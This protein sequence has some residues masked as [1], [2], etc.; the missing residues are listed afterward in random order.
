MKLAHSGVDEFVE[1][2]ATNLS[3]GGMFIRSREP[4][5]LGT[6]VNFKVEIAG[7]TRVL[8]GS[9]VV[10]WVREPND[11]NGPPGMGLEFS[12]LDASSEALVIRMLSG[13][14]STP[15]P[16]IPRPPMVPAVVAPRVAPPSAPRA[17][18]IAP[19]PSRPAASPPAKPPRAAP[20]APP[21]LDLDS[22]FGDLPVA[23]G[24]PEVEP[25]SSD[26]QFEAPPPPGAGEIEIDLETLIQ[27]TP[28]PPPPGSEPALPDDLPIAEAM[29]SLELDIDLSRDTSPADADIALQSVP[30]YNPPARAA[31]AAPPHRP[32][33]APPAPV[34]KAPAAPPPPADS[35]L[36]EIRR[37][38][39]PPGPTAPS[40]PAVL[41]QAVP[42]VPQMRAAPG[43][44]VFLE[45]PGTIDPTGPVIGIDLGTTNSCCA[46]LNKGKPQ[47]L[48]SKEGY[49]T[50]PS[51]VALGKQG[52]LLVGNRAKS[53]MLLNPSQSIYGAKRLVGRDF[54][55]ATVS[56][57]R[58]R[59][60]YD[61]VAG[62]DGKAAVNLGANTLSL[63]EVQGIVLR[64]CKQMA[65][66]H[67]GQKVSRAVITCPAYYSESQ[68]EAV[69]RAAAMA[70]LKVERVLNEPTAAALAYGLNREMSRRVLVYDLGGGTFDA[71]LMRID[72]NVFEVMATGGDIFLG[73]LDFDNQ[74][75]D[76]LLSKFQK[77]NNVTF[78]GDAVALSR[79]SDQAER[80]KVALSERTTFEVHLPML[81]MSNAGVPLELKCTLT[82]EELNESCGTLV[83]RTIDVV[84]DVLLD[85]NI[86]AGDIDDV[87]LVGGMSRMPL[88]REKIKG[89]FKKPPQASVN[90][91]EAVALGAALYSGTV[92]KV[93]SVVLIDVVPMT[94]GLGLPGG[95]FK[96]IVERNTPLPASKSFS[97]ATSKDNEETME[98]QVFQGEDANVG[99]NEYLGTMRIEGLPKGPKGSV[100]LAVTLKL[101][102][103]CV[104]H[105]DARE[106]RTRKA[107][108]S[109]LATRY[110]PDEIRTR[111]GMSTVKATPA[112]AQRAEELKQRGGRFWGFLKRVVGRA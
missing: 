91:D 17:P 86:K 28:P 60:H 27:Q 98:L 10:K 6:V 19:A 69:R 81:Q 12:S 54:D 65:E 9:A 11:P 15:L 7:G 82:R 32:F 96:R 83:D 47:I 25:V 106:L 85:A 3:P 94:I 79:V 40:A 71:T 66:Q 39:P 36:P 50:I 111:L 57:V 61:I 37:G 80:A 88:V 105:V 68:R 67:L 101:D 97:L 31:P 102:A 99:A 42:V 30:S 52:N 46:V 29:D 109:T 90:A 74:I 58:E 24:A 38:G 56:E 43:K 2:Y 104:L 62:P 16:Q 20:A 26:Y 4:K 75:V 110:T 107:F 108:T 59:F 84:R 53:Q 100:Q 112:T 76:T 44:P 49:N 93:S 13:K 70:G 14:A 45:P 95:G 72:K 73:G 51:V 87:I 1:K 22:I 23:P 78:N 92:D 18:A 55:S 103:E 48:S 21:A 64:E 33:V 89:V 77:Q 35:V 5:P 34:A 8:Q 41:R 63:E